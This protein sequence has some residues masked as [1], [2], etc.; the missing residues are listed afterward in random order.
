MLRGEIIMPL[1]KTPLHIAAEA[2]DAQVLKLLIEAGEWHGMGW[3]PELGPKPVL[4]PMVPTLKL[5]I[6]AGEWLGAR[7]GSNA[8]S[9]AGD[10]HV[11]AADRSRCV[12][13]VVP[14][15]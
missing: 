8:C 1:D 5:L 2:G 12:G 3:V 7:V 15:H 10:A 13:W 4:R 6:E 14:A 11:E 9:E